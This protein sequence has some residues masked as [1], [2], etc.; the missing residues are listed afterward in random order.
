MWPFKKKEEKKIVTKIKV[1]ELPVLR[2]DY[3]IVLRDGDRRQVTVHSSCPNY[4]FGDHGEEPNGTIS[5]KHPNLEYDNFIYL[6]NDG[7]EHH[8]KRDDIKELIITPV[9]SNGATYK[10]DWSYEEEVNE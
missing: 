4:P 6:T 2:L 7:H 3:M 10:V 8:L 1:I 5:P 9:Y